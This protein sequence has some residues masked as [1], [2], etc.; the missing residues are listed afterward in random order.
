MVFL[1]VTVAGVGLDGFDMDGLVVVSFFGA[2]FFF[3]LCVCA[4]ACFLTGCCK[5]AVETEVEGLVKSASF[6]PGLVGVVWAA[7]TEL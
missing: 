1:D 3:E 7:F 4:L 6:E 2:V 5:G